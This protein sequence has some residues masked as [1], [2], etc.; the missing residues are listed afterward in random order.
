MSVNA[1]FDNLSDEQKAICLKEAT[2]RGSTPAASTSGANATQ[3]PRK[4]FVVTVE[5]YTDELN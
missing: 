3:S 4:I 5:G 2:R 1:A